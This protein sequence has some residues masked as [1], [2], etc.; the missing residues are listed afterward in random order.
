MTPRA[1]YGWRVTGRS[2]SVLSSSARP[3]LVDGRRLSSAVKIFAFGFR[4]ICYSGN[5]VLNRSPCP[6]WPG[7]TSTGVPWVLGWAPKGSRRFLAEIRMRVASPNRSLFTRALL[8]SLEEPVPLQ[9]RLLSDRPHGGLGAGTMGSVAVD[10]ARKQVRHIPAM[11]WDLTIRR[12]RPGLIASP[13][14]V[15]LVHWYQGWRE[16]GPCSS[17]AR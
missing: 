12:F 10:S 6:R 1:R 4:V 9:R 15:C 3:L 13:S 16:R 2:V 5:A 11:A 7:S 17:P 14:R 8:R